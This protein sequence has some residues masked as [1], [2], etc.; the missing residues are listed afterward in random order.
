[1]KPGLVLLAGGASRRLRECKALVDLDGRTPL[2]RLL[3]A[4]AC[5]DSYAP[6]VV[7]GAVSSELQA[8]LPDGAEF[9]LNEAWSTGR[10]SSV[11]RAVRARAGLDLCLA[12]VDVPLVPASVFEA[13]ASAWLAAGAPPRGWLA[14]RQAGRHG[15]PIVV[16]RQLLAE[17]ES[18]L[19]ERPELSLREL[20]SAA[21]PLLDVE[22]AAVEVHDDL[23]TPLDLDRLRARFESN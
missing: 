10:T 23:D 22:V 21:E 8:A 1:M 14:P 11:L 3:T 20:R 16:G 18:T 5:L 7:G 6:L 9:V 17:L 19:A 15:H 13:L 12:P 2:A 4:G